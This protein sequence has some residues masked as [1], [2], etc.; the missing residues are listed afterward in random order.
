MGLTSC[1]PSCCSQQC[2][3]HPHLRQQCRTLHATAGDD[4]QASRGAFVRLTECLE[5]L[6]LHHQSVVCG[7]TT[8]LLVGVLLDTQLLTPQEA[9]TP[10][11]GS[12]NDGSSS[13]S[14]SGGVEGSSRTV[15]KAPVD[16]A[17]SAARIAEEAEVAKGQRTAVITGA[18]SIVF[19]VR[20]HIN[21]LK[22]TSRHE[23]QRVTLVC[24][25][26]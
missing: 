13:S 16:P 6:S 11:D 3:P 2:R 10:T 8:A 20:F 21:T 5:V 17:K 26:S 24:S 23:L 22:S 4:Q 1:W 7:V 9:S 15:Q 25:I 12:S 18:V 14:T 19:G